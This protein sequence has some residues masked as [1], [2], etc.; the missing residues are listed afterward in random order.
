MSSSDPSGQTGEAPSSQAGALPSSHFPF[1]GR[2]SS[3]Q[4]GL[5]LSLQEGLPPS[6]GSAGLAGVDPSVQVLGFSPSEQL[7]LLLSPHLLRSGA[8]PSSQR[9]IPPS[10]QAGLQPSEQRRPPGPLPPSAP[11]PLLAELRA[12]KHTMRNSFMLMYS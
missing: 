2:E 3:E 12:T 7:G 1:L 8:D 10:E 6:H 4:D 9:G 5:E 11:G